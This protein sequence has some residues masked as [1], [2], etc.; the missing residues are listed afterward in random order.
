MVDLQSTWPVIVAAAQL[1]S[2]PTDLRLKVDAAQAAIVKRL[3]ELG[4]LEEYAPEREALREGLRILRR[5]QIERLNY[6]LAPV[7]GR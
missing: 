1:E 4:S 7:L 5:L 3:R 6:P 2:D